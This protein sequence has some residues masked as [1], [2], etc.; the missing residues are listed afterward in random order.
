MGGDHAFSYMHALAIG[1][2][3]LASPTLITPKMEVTALNMEK[4]QNCIKTY[5]TIYGQ[6]PGDVEIKDHL[7][8]G[9]QPDGVNWLKPFEISQADKIPMIF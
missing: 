9:T 7:A 4:A 6:D 1:L 5:R 3:D 2:R 8:C